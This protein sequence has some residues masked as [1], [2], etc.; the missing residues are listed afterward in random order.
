MHLVNKVVTL[1]SCGQGGK[2][3]RVPRA[4]C[5]CP[6]PHPCLPTGT[7]CVPG[8]ILSSGDPSV[9]ATAGGP[10]SF[11]LAEDTK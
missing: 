7:F 11:I 2:G 3:P 10:D 4:L 9:R 6:C 1:C 5:H 8:T